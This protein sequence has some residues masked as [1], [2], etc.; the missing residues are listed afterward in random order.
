[1][2][3]VTIIGDGAMATVCAQLLCEPS[4]P[5]KPQRVTMWAH[6]PSHIAELA[7]TRENKRFLPGFP[8]PQSLQLQP[9]D[10][11]AF[12]GATLIVCAIPTQF[13]RPTLTRL[14]PHIPAGIP[15]V[16]VAKGLELKTMQRPSEVITNLTGQNRPIAALSGPNIAGEIARRLPATAVIASANPEFARRLQDSF[17]T[18]WFRVYT[19]DDLLGVELG[20]ALKNVIAL[21]AGILDGMHAGNNAKAALL[22]RGLVEITRLATALGAKPETFMGLAGLGDLVTTCVS[23]EGRNRTFGERIGNG[24]KADAVLA[25]MRGVVEGVPTTHS[26]IT[27]ARSKNIEMPI[28][29]SLHAVLFEGKDPK[30]QLADLMSRESKQ[31]D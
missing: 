1:M 23:P 17:T 29:E 3:N 16:S 20:G 10:A 21:A 5:Q 6:D 30:A 18:P 14:A 24:E 11:A 15:I 4:S 25:T 13:I 22:T 28:A 27:L 8:L 7:R 26:V 2:N 9:D 12:T 31:E 19:N